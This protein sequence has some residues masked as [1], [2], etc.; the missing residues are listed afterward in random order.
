MSKEHEDQPKDGPIIT[1]LLFTARNIP[2][3]L[4]KALGGFATNGV[5]LLKIESYI[6]GPSSKTAQFFISFEGH[7]DVKNVQLAIE[8]LGF[9]CKKVK[10]LGVYPAD[11]TF[12]LNLLSLKVNVTKNVFL[13]LQKFFKLI[14]CM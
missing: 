11:Q 6:L 3:A 5:N 2:A 14:F 4:Y 7:P 13:Y 10:L 12:Y 9:F 8:E 1:S